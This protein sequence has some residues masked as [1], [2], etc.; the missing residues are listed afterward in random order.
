MGT[1]DISRVNFDPKKH[2]SSL[3]MQQGRV[4]TEDDYN[5]DNRIHEEELRRSMVDIIGSFGSPD[6]GFKI[7]NLRI[8]VAGVIGRI[9]FDILAGTLYLGGLRLE[10]EDLETYRLQKDWLLQPFDLD[11][12]PN[13]ISPALERFD[14]VYIEACQPEVC[15]VEDNSLFEVALGGPDTTTR[16]RTMRRVHL[17]ADL[18]FCDCADAWQQLLSNWKSDHLGTVNREFERITDVILKV[19]FSNSGL[20]EDLCTPSAAGGYLGAENQ[21]IRVQI[22]DQTHFTWGFDNA[23]PLYRVMVTDAGQTVT[24][25]TEPKDQYHW[26]LSNQV[27]EILPWSAVLPNGEK[28]SEQMGHL[29]RVDASYKPDEGY[30]TLTDPVPATFGIDWKSRSDKDDLDNQT[31][32]EYFYMRV[33]NRGD[34]LSSSAAINFT[35]GIP[36][37]LGHTGLEV[38]ITGTEIVAPDYW[39]IAA[40]PE[41]PNRVVPWELEQGIAPH[42]V[43]RFFAPLAVI[44][45]SIESGQIVGEIMHDC[46]RKFGPLTQQECCCTYSVGDG[47]RSTGD[48]NSIQEAVDNLPERG[49]KICVLPGEHLASVIIKNRRQIQ[50]SGCGD[51][52]I[53]RPEEN[54]FSEPIFLI[55]NSQKIQI[56]Q[57][58]LYAENG[59]AIALLDNTANPTMPLTGPGRSSTGLRDNASN[60][61]LNSENIKINNNQII[62]FQCAVFIHTAEDRGGENNIEILYNKIGII[63]KEQK[64]HGMKNMP[65]ANSQGLP[66]IFSVAD[67]VLI[68]RNRIIVIPPQKLDD[69]GDPRNDDPRDGDPFNPCLDPHLVYKNGFSLRYQIY[70]ML[71]Y[72]YLYKPTQIKPE[73]LAMGGIQ[74]GGTSE[75]VMIRQNEIIGGSGYGI[76][77]GHQSPPALVISSTVIKYS[78]SA[79]FEIAIEENQIKL[80][81]LAGIGVLNTGEQD[82]E[83]IVHIEDLIIYRNRITLCAFQIPERNFKIM[84]SPTS[85]NAIPHGGIILGYCENG[86]I[87]ENRIE[88]NGDNIENPICGIFILYGEKMDISNNSIINNGLSEINPNSVIRPGARGGIVIAMSF[89]IAGLKNT[90]NAKI[91]SFDGVPSLTAHNN[92]VVQPLGHAL[93]LVAF[94]PVSV[95]S[96]H[97]TSLGTDKTNSFSRLAGSVFIFNLGI[98]KDLPVIGLKNLPNTSGASASKSASINPAFQFLPSGK[99]MFSDNQTTLDTKSVSP[100]FAVSSQ[101]IFSL[102]DVAFNNNQS[103]CAGLISFLEFGINISDIVL[104]NTLL[105]GASLR[106]NDN[107]LLEGFTVT[108]FSLVSYGFINT[109]IGNQA[110]HCMIVM[111]AKTIPIPMG[112]DNNII[113]NDSLC[114]DKTRMVWTSMAVPIRK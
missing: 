35:T 23:S 85:Q 109:A 54:R 101:L 82:I 31:P 104:F 45:W 99:V 3:R 57:L 41:T 50:I 112:Y 81:G 107:R 96:N 56:E 34:D 24:M 42:G 90:A 15:A 55:E 51:Q 25:L 91:P 38:T 103:E 92:I 70:S 1:Y 71:R 22:I 40:R 53:I 79:L 59:I 30:L 2:Y 29:S 9:N 95:V 68:E 28:V 87:Q 111:G 110:S 72:L 60:P 20:P 18:G 12:A 89:K 8:D 75:R 37:A 108:V 26:P 14:L 52:S 69:P 64:Y 94:G 102:D 76:L 73:Y 27:V 83:H 49:G 74:I 13:S 47:I 19:T 97:F 44:R 5:E 63:D 11:Q 10:M 66:A 48:F 67:H 6:S 21:A 61:I 77:L 105:F 65:Q 43:R 86:K 17:A 88:D 4:L 80:M 36:V 46:R 106:S 16:L 93:Y 33:W 98:S 62:A 78:Y 58:T 114:N 100:N 113:L 7:E 39:V 32:P 84:L